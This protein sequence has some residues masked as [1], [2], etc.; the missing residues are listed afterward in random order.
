MIARSRFS[1]SEGRTIVRPLE[2][3]LAHCRD[4]RD[5]DGSVP[6]YGERE[7]R[8]YLDCGILAHGFVRARCG[9]CGHTVL[10][11]FSGKGRGVC[12]SSNARRIAEVAAHRVE[13]VFPVLPV[14]QWVLSIP[15]R[16]R[17]FLQRDAAALSAV[18]LI[19]LRAI[20]ARLR[21]ASHCPDGR[22]G[23][24]SFVHRFGAALNAHWGTIGAARLPSGWRCSP[25]GEGPRVFLRGDRRQSESSPRPTRQRSVSLAAAKRPGAMSALG[26]ARRHSWALPLLHHRR[27]VG[28]RRGRADPLRRGGGT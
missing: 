22:L 27:H 10:I 20:E 26:R 21:E 1:D 5:D 6:E 11:A 2:T 15:K 14:P 3:W 19:L 18:L 28:R 25:R 12:P 13:H 4:G 7:F 9:D 8:R 17:Y 24:V 16:L 23:A